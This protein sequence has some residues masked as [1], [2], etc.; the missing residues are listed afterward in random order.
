MTAGLVLTLWDAASPAIAVIRRSGGRYEN[1]E[2]LAMRARRRVDA[3][4][5]R[6][7]YPRGA[8]RMPFD[9]RW[10]TEDRAAKRAAG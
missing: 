4:Q 9:D 10:L 2:Y 7:D 6:D 3:L 5:G 8:Q 1:F